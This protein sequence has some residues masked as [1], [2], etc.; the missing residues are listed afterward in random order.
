MG[1]EKAVIKPMAD[2]VKAVAELGKP[3]VDL[4]TKLAG[5][6]A[7]EIGLTIGDHIHIVRFKRQIRLLQ[8]A[9]KFLDEAGIEAKRV[10]LKLLGSILEQGSLEEDDELQDRWAAL[11]ASAASHE[12]VV[13]PSFP[14]ILK[15]LTKSDGLVLDRLC[16][17][18][19]LI[20]KN[21]QGIP[22]KRTSPENIPLDIERTLGTLR[23][24]GS[25]AEAA[26]HRESVE[27]LTRL[28]LLT[29]VWKVEKPAPSLFGA[30]EPPLPKL[31]QRARDP[32]LTRHYRMTLTGLAF[33]RAC[34]QPIQ[35]TAARE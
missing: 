9:K 33:W 21:P 11:L 1:D 2:A 25:N 3:L 35:R 19:E 7:E 22:L 24:K 27:N 14:E 8:N 29:V 6:A 32:Y 13:P 10:P 30:E 34:T 16:R 17:E 31:L 26:D 15:Q 18:I 4:L 12:G 5:P 23:Y 20:I 28:G